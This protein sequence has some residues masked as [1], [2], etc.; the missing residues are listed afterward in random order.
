V[1]NAL[2]N[3]QKGH[4]L[5]AIKLLNDSKMWPEHLG[6]G[7]PFNPDTRLQDYATALCFQRLGN[8]TKADSMF[9]AIYDY[10]VTHWIG[11]G[12]NHYVG[13]LILKRF[14]E[15]HKAEQL[16]DDWSAMQ[17]GDYYL[18]DPEKFNMAVWG[19]VKFRNELE[20][21]QSIEN[22]VLQQTNFRR[23]ASRNFVTLVKAMQVL[24]E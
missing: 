23:R 12:W 13:A 22:Q 20:K 3:Y 2:E 24:E 14:G 7:T 5:Q 21:I 6:V 11:K 17:G 8:E 15:S 9:K 19:K 1:F 10:T 16:I 4:Y 18:A